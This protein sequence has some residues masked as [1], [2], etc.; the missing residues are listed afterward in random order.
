MKTA[1]NKLCRKVELLFRHLLGRAS[2]HLES[3]S[4]EPTSRNEKP[5]VER[6][7]LRAHCLEHDT[8]R[9]VRDRPSL[10]DDRLA[11]TGATVRPMEQVIQLGHRDR[12]QLSPCRECFRVLQF[13]ALSGGFHM[14]EIPR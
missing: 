9:T 14:T 3:H 11:I 13:D 4:G 2:F 7:G 12:L 1:F 5:V 6:A 10:A 8:G